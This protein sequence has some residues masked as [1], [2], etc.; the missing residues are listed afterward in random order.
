MIDFQKIMNN[1]LI[2]YEV[3]H[4]TYNVQKIST[5]INNEET[6]DGEN[7][8]LNFKDVEAAYSFCENFVKSIENV[9]ECQIS[10]AFNPTGL[11]L[12]VVNLGTIKAAS[13]DDALEQGQ[14]LAANYLIENQLKD[15]I[16]DDYEIKVIL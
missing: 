7:S 11:S 9:R 15:R 4:N 10:M 14:K 8:T 3:E 1:G 12:K 6:L 16:K 2:I 5:P 13:Y